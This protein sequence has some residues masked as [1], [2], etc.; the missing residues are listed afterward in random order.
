MR[1]DAYSQ[2]QHL[3]GTQQ[4]KSVAKPAVKA[5]T[6]DALQISDA[7]RDYQIA[8]KAVSKAADVRA[9]RVDALKA[10]IAK[11]TYDVS[12][13]DFANKLLGKYDAFQALLS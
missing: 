6:S 7:G 9:E 13:D 10:E 11:G 12:A 1:I 5:R 3:Y 8:K 2:V 4:V